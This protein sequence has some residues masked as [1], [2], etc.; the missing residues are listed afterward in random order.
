MAPSPSPC[1]QVSAHQRMAWRRYHSGVGRTMWRREK[2]GEREKEGSRVGERPHGG[3][4]R[5]PPSWA[6]CLDSRRRERE[7]K[8]MIRVRVRCASRLFYFAR[9]RRPSVGSGWMAQIARATLDP[10][11]EAESWPRPR[12]R[13]GRGGG[14]ARVCVGAA[15]PRA[16]RSGHV[17]HA[18]AGEMGRGP[19]FSQTFVLFIFR[20]EF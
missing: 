8:E 18:R 4:R 3:H 12:L 14:T 20:S 13:P 15:R 9:E 7:K 1:Y 5:Q 10:G 2:I 16:A 6:A 19:V 11:G 17:S